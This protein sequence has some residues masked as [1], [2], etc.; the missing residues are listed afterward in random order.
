MRKPLTGSA[1]LP[2][3]Q[4]SRTGRQSRQK[5]AEEA[6][7]EEELRRIGGLHARQA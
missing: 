7:R 3:L 2:V 4:K 6:G 5:E 1:L